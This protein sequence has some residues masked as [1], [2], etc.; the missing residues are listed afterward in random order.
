MKEIKYKIIALGVNTDTKFFNSLLVLKQW[1]TYN[2]D[3]EYE[4]VHVTHENL[5]ELTDRYS[6]TS[7]PFFILI[8]TKL[9]VEVTSIEGNLNTRKLNT[10]LNFI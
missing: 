8:D 7:L 2:T 3:V 10:M 4:I 6:I 1:C 5:D 9:G